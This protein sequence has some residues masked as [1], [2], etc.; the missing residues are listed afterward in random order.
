MAW[1]NNGGD[2]QTVGD[3]RGVV[4]CDKNVVE[5]VAGWMVGSGSSC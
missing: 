5:Q 2:T 1:C 4:M 3:G